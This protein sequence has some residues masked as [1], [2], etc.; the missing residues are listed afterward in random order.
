MQNQYFPILPTDN[1]KTKV[2]AFY[3]AGGNANSFFAWTKDTSRKIAWIPFEI[4]GHGR[5]KKEPLPK[6]IQE[7]AFEAATAIADVVDDD[8]FVCWGHSMG[9]AVAFETVCCL[10]TYFGI[11]PKLLIVSAR[12]APHS[13]FTGLYHCA[14]GK[15]KLVEDMQRLGMIP[16]PLLHSQEFLDHVIPITF[17]DYQINEMYTGSQKI[18]SV[19]IVAHYG[20]KDAEAT[21]QVLQ[22]WQKITTST[23]T[24]QAFSGEHFYFFEK[25]LDYLHVIEDI[26]QDYIDSDWR[27]KHDF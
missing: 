26:V 2:F 25:S 7:I 21:E 22:E 18:L 17:N 9:S 16:E 6:S 11:R 23:F 27:E 4:A 24:M 14:D 19:P 3:H 20:D 8:N 5:R 1:T 15:E 10:E 13:Q 12:Q